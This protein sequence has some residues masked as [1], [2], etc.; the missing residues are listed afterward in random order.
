M[1][2][3]CSVIRAVARHSMLPKTA[4]SHVQSNTSGVVVQG[5]SFGCTLLRSYA[6][7]SKS[8]DLDPHEV[9][10]LE[11]GASLD[12]I[13]RQ[14]MKLSK[15]YHPDYNQGDEK[16]KERFIS[17]TDAY[18]MLIEKVRHEEPSSSF[19]NE[20]PYDFSVEPLGIETEKLEVVSFTRPIRQAILLGCAIILLV[21]AY[22]AITADLKE[23]YEEWKK[24]SVAEQERKIREEVRKA[25]IE[26]H[27]EQKQLKKLYETAAGQRN[28]LQELVAGQWKN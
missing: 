15:K 12:E 2:W 11:P 13:R 28:E 8:K 24:G 22:K 27:R 16:A 3:C 6:N 26:H 25:V 17:L 23:R 18:R 4:L 14:Y 19:E 1:V 5:Q 10:G 20:K 9:L 21:G 7:D